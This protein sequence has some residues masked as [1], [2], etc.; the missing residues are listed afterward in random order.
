MWTKL[1]T[2]Y[3]QRLIIELDCGVKTKA[4]NTIPYMLFPKYDDPKP[5]M[6]LTELDW[7]MTQSQFGSN[8]L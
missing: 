7:T 6:P 8:F 3:S 5:H 4:S 2:D 1:S